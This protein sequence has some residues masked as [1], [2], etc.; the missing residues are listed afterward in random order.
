[1]RPVRRS[2]STLLYINIRFYITWRGLT[3]HIG[4]NENMGAQ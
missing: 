2:K 1:M 3:C 4:A